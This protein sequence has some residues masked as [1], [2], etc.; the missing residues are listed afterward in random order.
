MV[1]VALMGGLPGNA[2]A[3]AR[4]LARTDG[5]AVQY[6]L[7]VPTERGELPLVVIAQG[8]GCIGARQSGSVKAVI[9]AF[10]GFPILTVEAYGVAPEQADPA[11]CPEAFLAHGTMSQ[12][13]EDYRLVLQA[14][15]GAA[16]WDGRIVLFG[17]SEGG[18]VVARL[19]GAVEAE[20]AILLSTAP[21]A[22]FDRIVLANVPP[23]GQETV[24]GLFE[25]AR[26]DP[27][28][29]EMLAGYPFR[30][31]ADALAINAVEDMLSS[32][33]QFL[34]IHGGQ[35]SVPVDYARSAADSYADAGR[36]E[37]TY[38]EFPAL[39]HGMRDIG[40]QTQ[41]PMIA[42]AAARWALASIKASAC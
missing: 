12:R 2:L 4:S 35:D 21:G 37:L 10:A 39:D 6:Q 18:L 5:S 40:G 22:R 41:M 36:C 31:W 32:D 20:A 8:S 9:D 25:R 19:A 38:W 14:L 1:A 16:W 24:A 15:E 33:T 13:V 26:A 42:E 3:D 27:G 17:G 30:F 23:E 28:S 11:N 29:M 34:V 7:D